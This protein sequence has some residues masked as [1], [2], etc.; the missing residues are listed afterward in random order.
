MNKEGQLIGIAS[1]YQYHRTMP[2]IYTRIS[3]YHNF[4]TAA[5][6]KPCQEEIEIPQPYLEDMMSS[7]ERCILE[8]D[9]EDGNLHGN[10]E[11]DLC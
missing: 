5:M 10:I 4:I 6:A 11:D 8:I 2:S 3:T 1:S 7:P 9:S